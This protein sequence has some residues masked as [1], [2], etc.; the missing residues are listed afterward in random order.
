M[1]KMRYSR[2]EIL[3]SNPDHFSA[4]PFLKIRIEENRLLPEAS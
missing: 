1:V 3:G 2:M 4:I